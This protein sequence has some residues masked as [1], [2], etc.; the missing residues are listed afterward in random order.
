[1]YYENFVKNEKNS[2]KNAGKTKKN[3]K[4]SIFF[5]RKFYIKKNALRLRR[6]RMITETTLDIN[7]KV[8]L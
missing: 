6:F 2:Y 4:N 7:G 1:M 5:K 8:P 3:Y